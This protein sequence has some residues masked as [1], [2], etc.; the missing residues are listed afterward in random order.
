MGNFGIYNYIWCPIANYQ[1]EN[2]Y[3]FDES[4]HHELEFS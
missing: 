1:K 4:V 2:V 3:N